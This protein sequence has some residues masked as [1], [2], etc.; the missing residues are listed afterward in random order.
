MKDC[1]NYKRVVNAFSIRC[2]RWESSFI[3]GAMDTAIV[4]E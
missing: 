3:N 4:L 2:G 1:Y